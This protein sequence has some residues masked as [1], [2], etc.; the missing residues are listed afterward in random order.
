V[1][2]LRVRDLHAVHDRDLPEFLKRLGL[3][4]AIQQCR[5][6]CASCG[7]PITLDNFG[8]AYPESGEIRVV[9]DRLE[10]VGP[11]L[12]EKVQ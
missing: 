5:V 1:A 10:C 12:K 9:C 2:K 6:N 7:G 11:L 8:G 4:D 3:L